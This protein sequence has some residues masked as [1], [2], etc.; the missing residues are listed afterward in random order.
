MDYIKRKKKDR[1]KCNICGE[2]KQLT[3]NHVPPKSTG[4]SKEILANLLI[5][6]FPESDKY[7]KKYQNGIRFRTICQECNNSLIGEYDM[8]YKK[9]I[10]DIKN[11][12][13]SELIL[14]KYIKIKVKINRVCRA[15]CGHF[16]AA[17]DYYDD[18]II[19]DKN[20]VTM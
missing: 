18:E 1:D 7:Q 8:D 17:K 2:E 12:L 11:I 3:W 4:N 10:E 5:Q 20:Y 13:K 14:P 19:L 6:G 15:I 16:L 9:I